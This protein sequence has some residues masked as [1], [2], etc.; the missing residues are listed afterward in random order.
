MISLHSLYK[1][2]W[3]TAQSPPILSRC[4][5]MSLLRGCSQIKLLTLLNM[6]HNK[7]QLM[8]INGDIFVHPWPSLRS[9]SPRLPSQ[10]PPTPQQIFS[11]IFSSPPWT[12]LLFP[13]L[14]DLKFIFIH[15][16]ILLM[17][18]SDS[19][20]STRWELVA[21]EGLSDSRLLKGFWRSPKASAS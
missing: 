15:I 2:T 3:A 11:E 10:D 14:Q 9:M 19:P 12:P 16:Y 20:L 18:D 7:W 17:L 13:L 8:A 1:T 21:K 6:L 5:S 4:M